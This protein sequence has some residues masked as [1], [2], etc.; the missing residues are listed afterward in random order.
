MAEREGLSGIGF[1]SSAP[2]SHLADFTLPGSTELFA[3]HLRLDQRMPT[4]WWPSPHCPAGD[5]AVSIGLFRFLQV[6]V[7]SSPMAKNFPTPVDRHIG[8]RVRMQR[9]ALDTTQHKLAGTIGIAIQQVR[10]YESGA[11]RV[12]AGRLQ[13]IALALHVTPAFLFDEAPAVNRR[14]KSAGPHRGACFFAKGHRPFTSL[15]QNQ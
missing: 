4:T 2:G 13:R 8:M 9:R 7:P 10:K 11:N 3:P 12:S 5:E 15:G 6:L 1:K 14:P